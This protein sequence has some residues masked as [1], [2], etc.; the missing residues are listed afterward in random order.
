MTDK[1]FTMHLSSEIVDV[2]RKR[3]DVKDELGLRALVADAI[4][5]YVRLG[6]LAAGGA[7]FYARDKGKEG[8]VRVHFP[9]DPDPRKSAPAGEK[10]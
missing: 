4:N 2:L 8:L 3:V 6:T 10:A 7:T 5:T 9:F 1:P